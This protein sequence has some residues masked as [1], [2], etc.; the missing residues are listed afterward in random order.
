[1]W[2]LI[3]GVMASL[4]ACG[5]L[6]WILLSGIWKTLPDISNPEAFLASQS[7]VILD[8]EGNELYRFFQEEDRTTLTEGDTPQHVTDAIIAIED[9]RFYQRRGCIDWRAL[10]RAILANISSYKSQGAST[11]TQQLVRTAFL[12][13]EKTIDRKIREIMLACQ[14]ESIL[15]KQEIL[16]LYLNWISFGH[17]IGGMRQAARRYFGVDVTDLSLAQSAL[18]ASLPQRPSYFSPY[19]V[20]RKTTLTKEALQDVWEGRIQ[21]ASDIEE[22]DVVI[23]LVGSIV[24]LDEGE[25]LLQ[26]R[27]DIVLDALYTQN[28]ITEEEYREAKGALHS[29]SI[30][31]R[32]DPIHA[33]HFVIAIREFIEDAMKRNETLRPEAGITIHTTIDP[34]LQHAAETV[35]TNASTWLPSQWSGSNIALITVHPFTGEILSYVGNTN[36]FDDLHGG[37]IDMART[38]RQTGSAFKPFIYALLMEQG[39][40]TE[41]RIDD[42]PLDP[43]IYNPYSRG[44]YGKMTIRTALGRS[45]NTPAVR[46]YYAVGGENVIL[47]TAEAVG[48]KSP[49]RRKR[50]MQN[51]DP[52]FRY[53]WSLALGAGEASLLEMVEGYSTLAN[54]GMHQSLIG[55][56][57]ITNQTGAILFAPTQK[58]TR[59][60]RKESAMQ[61][62]DILS[63]EE[64]RE[65]DWQSH[66]H[67]P[68]RTAALKTGT[69]NLCLRRTNDGRCREIIPS[70]TWAIGW[71]GDLLVG[72]WVGNVDNAPMA[73]ETTS[74]ETAVPIWKAFM[75]EA[76]N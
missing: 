51:E 13:R 50:A 75:E 24:T 64:A 35:V 22:D 73:K 41:S 36:F 52:Q 21:R 23:G 62:E 17:N 46:A 43:D 40:T 1:M 39:Y 27:S 28:L 48:I 4:V 5:L 72:V 15:T 69:S 34:T 11:I 31:P 47:D 74:L 60:F 71:S 19:G 7:I 67:L 32:S 30:Q 9:K 8:R 61:I 25:V 20:H 12:T 45:R 6:V 56:T 54:N 68:G 63:D 29:L 3:N 16:S 58:R 57:A 2:L 26:G 37:Q 65:S 44:F 76:L 55:I 53:A 59:V 42:K 33:P 14:L 38:P 10:G 70:N 49:K 18:L 66:M